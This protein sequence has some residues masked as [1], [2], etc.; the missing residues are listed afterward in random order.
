[1]VPTRT[2]AT[3]PLVSEAT[4]RKHRN[5]IPFKPGQ[6]GNP[7]GRPRG[8]RNRLGE[9][10]L[11]HLCEDFAAHG[12]AAIERVRQED[13]ATYLRVIASLVP[14][15]LKVKTGPLVGLTEAEL[16]ALAHAA[17]KAVLQASEAAGS[18]T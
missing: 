4:E 3:Q 2:Q 5:L 9:D 13:P 1:M 18:G 7:R 6:S 14:K 16:N 8:A 12:Q 15:E 17:Q 10:F 11:G